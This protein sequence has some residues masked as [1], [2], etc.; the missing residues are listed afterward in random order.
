MK[1]VPID[2]NYNISKFEL[3][4]TSIAYPT[5]PTC[6]SSSR[7]LSWASFYLQSVIL[8]LLVTIPFGNKKSLWLRDIF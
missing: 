6:Y 2:V 5:D 4:W 3:H 8:I 7:E 1:L